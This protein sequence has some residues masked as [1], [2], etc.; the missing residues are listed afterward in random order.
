MLKGRLQPGKM[1]VASLEEGRIIP[2]EEIKARICSAEPY[3]AWL[4]EGKISL[5]ELEPPRQILQPP[6]RRVLTRQTCLRLHAGGP[7]HPHGAHGP[8]R[9]G[10]ARLDGQRHAAGRAVLQVAEPLRLLPPALRAGHQPAHRLHPRGDGHEPRLLRGRRGQR[11]GLRAGARAHHRAASPRPHQRGPGAPALGG[12]AALPGQDHLH[13]LRGQA[14]PH[15]ARARA[16]PPRGRGVRP[17]RL[18]GHHPHRPPRRF[19]PRRHPGAAG[20]L[21]GPPP[22][23]PQGPAL[24]HRPHRGDRRGSRGAPLRHPA[25]VR[26]LCHQPLPGP[27]DHRGHA[28]PRAPARIDGRRGGPRALSQGHRQGS[29]QDDV[30]DGHLHDVVVHRRPDLRGRGA[31]RRGR[32]G[33]LPGHGLTH[34]RHRRG[35]HRARD[36]HAP[37]GRLRRRRRRHG[38]GAGR[39]L[40]VAPARR[41][42]PPRP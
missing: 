40:P 9:P 32:R 12:S 21:H 3:Q 37:R 35:H 15:A 14:G 8:G 31:R 33:A 10:A 39:P 11:A 42:A 27:R 4:D 41:A 18:R 38:P 36:P 2:D 23:H 17:R 28:P 20:R 34:R 19:G 13:L 16:T 5:A 24:A 25:R 29:P 30:Q 22:P 1:F 6:T 7:A 26:R